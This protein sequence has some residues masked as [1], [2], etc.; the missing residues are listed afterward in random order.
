VF[1]CEL[2]L[3]GDPIAVCAAIP[4]F[5]LTAQLA[6]IS[7]PAFSQA[8]AAEKTDF[9]LGLI[10]PA[11]MSGR[12]V[13]REAIPQPSANLFPK[14]VGQRLAGVG[15]QV[16]NDQMN[17]VCCRIVRGDLQDEIGKLGRGTCRCHFGEMDARLRFDS[18]EDICRTTAL[19]LVISS[20][21]VAGLHGHHRPRISMQ[22]H[23]LFVHANHRFAF[24]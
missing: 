11:S 3:N 20:G 23:R 18:A 8:L 14:A 13:H 1:S 22:N 16:V 24:R 21:D 10:Q 19:V 5:G 15:A 4:C 6:N 2:P 9:Y 12:V 17:G 7:D